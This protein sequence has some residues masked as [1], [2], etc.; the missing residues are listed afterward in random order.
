MYD[1][2]GDGADYEYALYPEDV[3]LKINSDILYYLIHI[4]HTYYSIVFFPF[5]PLFITLIPY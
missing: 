4:H 3:G 1:I 2:F 5:Y